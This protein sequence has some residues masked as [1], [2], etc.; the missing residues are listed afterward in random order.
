MNG[1]QV[2]ILSTRELVDSGLH[3][4]I[5][6]LDRTNMAAVLEKAGIVFPEEK[7]RKAFEVDGVYF[8]VFDSAGGVLAYLEICPD[9]E[10]PRE[11][12]YISS[13]QIVPEWRGGALL[14]RLLAAAVGHLQNHPFRLLKSA[15]QKANL[16]AIEIYRKLGFEMAENPKSEKSLLLSANRSILS[17]PFARRLAKAGE[18]NK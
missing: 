3:D 1:R 5:V 11:D 10:N 7:R 6:E 13:L 8:I 4:A 18:L 15:V 17:T 16:P 12:L 9:W 2:Q 14:G